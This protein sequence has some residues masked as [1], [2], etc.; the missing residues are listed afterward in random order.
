MTEDAA[1]ARGLLRAGWNEKG[2]GERTGADGVQRDEAS[3]HA[4]ATQQLTT[5]C[6][7][8]GQTVRLFTRAQRV[9]SG[10]LNPETL[11]PPPSGAE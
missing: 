5:R 8:I 11:L 6:T 9:V 10:Q 3:A 2:L 4:R 7:G 1:A